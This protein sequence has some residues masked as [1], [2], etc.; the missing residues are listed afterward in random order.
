MLVS[1]HAFRLLR[2]H[3]SQTHAQTGALHPEAEVKKA[4]VA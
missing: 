4:T 1:L 3:S 2:R